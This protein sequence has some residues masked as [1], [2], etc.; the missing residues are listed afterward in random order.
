VAAKN[1]MTPDVVK[2][3]LKKL[4]LNE[5][6]LAIVKLQEEEEESIERGETNKVQNTLKLTRAKARELNQKPFPITPYKNHEQD[7]EVTALI[8]NDIVSDD[9]DAEYEPNEDDIH[10]DDNTTI[11]DVDSQPMTPVS[12][13][14]SNVRRILFT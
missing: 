7:S 12:E 5:H 1:A 10:S 6:V 11:S 8:H 4:V 14:D 9:E 3:I 2:K 13:S